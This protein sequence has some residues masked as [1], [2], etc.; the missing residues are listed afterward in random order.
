MEVGAELSFAYLSRSDEHIVR[1][2]EFDHDSVYEWLSRSGHVEMIPSLPSQD[3]YLWMVGFTEREVRGELQKKLFNALSG[4]SAVWKFRNILYHED[5]T[6]RRWENF[7][8]QKLVE[9]A[10]AWFE[11]A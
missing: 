10:R 2:H 3:L 7:K 8:R 5:E 11:A 9:A 1:V 6:A 4:V